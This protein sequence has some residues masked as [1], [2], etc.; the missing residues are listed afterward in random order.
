MKT[1]NPFL[2]QKKIQRKL[3]AIFKLLR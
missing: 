1:L 2:I 3:K